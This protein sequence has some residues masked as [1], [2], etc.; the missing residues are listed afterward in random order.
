MPLRQLLWKYI[1]HAAKQT[2][3]EV[4]A[5]HISSLSCSS[6][7]SPAN[8][9]ALFMLRTVSIRIS[10]T[11]SILH[12]WTSLTCF[13]TVRR[14]SDSHPLMEVRSFYTLTD[15]TRYWTEWKVECVRCVMFDEH[16]S[17]QPASTA[18]PTFHFM[19]GWHL[20]TSSSV[21]RE[22]LLYLRITLKE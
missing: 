4:S 9:K 3:L 13:R 5:D 7:L 17:G 11:Q 14:L 8:K 21:E 15:R 19:F 12:V 22:L 20:Q 18:C 10:I 2:V 6:S 16:A 1:H